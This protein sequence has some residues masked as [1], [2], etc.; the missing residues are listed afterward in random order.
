MDKTRAAHVAAVLGIFY[1]QV[2]FVWLDPGADLANKICTS[3]AVLLTLV[4][5][6]PRSQSLAKTIVL[7]TTFALGLLVAHLTTRGTFGTAAAGVLTTAAAVFARLP[8][9]LS[10][11]RPAPGAGT[12]GDVAGSSGPGTGRGNV[13]PIASVRGPGDEG[14]GAGGGGGGE[15]A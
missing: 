14:G 15:A 8:A 4:F 6:D 2:Q 10:A 7:T 12:E 5:T 13:V 3:V 11:A 9:A 1:S